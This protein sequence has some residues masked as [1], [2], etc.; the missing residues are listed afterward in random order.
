VVG[1]TQT[2]GQECVII[3]FEGVGDLAPVGTISTPLG[4]AEFSADAIGLVDTDAGGSGPF[5]NEPSPDT[6]MF[7]FT[8]EPVI[9]MTLENPAEEVSWFYSSPVP[10]TVRIF[11]ESDNLIEVI[12]QA[13]TLP[14][15]GDPTGGDFG[16][17]VGDDFN[18][19]ANII[20]KV[21]FD[22]TLNFSIWDNID[23]CQA[24]DV[25]GGEFLPID[26]TVLL[27]TAVQSPT[28]LWISGLLSVVGVGAFLFT[29]NP[30][31]T[32]NVKVILQDYLDKF[33]KTD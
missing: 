4:D 32:R 14:G 1:V 12:N 22:G 25:V 15:P 33:G 5:A 7:V 21:E 13:A 9:T 24:Q 26:N 28:L 19:G 11:D 31:N 10:S 20:K 17:W 16:T 18:A 6:I 23:F 8:G 3:D 2:N 29:R 27:L 30:N